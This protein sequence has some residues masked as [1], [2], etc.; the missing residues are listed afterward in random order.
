MHELGVVLEIFDLIEEIMQERNLKE[1]CSVTVEIGELSGV[2]PDYLKECWNA[3]RIGGTFDKT[4]LKLI[5]IPSVARC[6]CGEEYEMTKNSRICPSCRR[7]DYEI[8]KGREFN[9]LSIEAR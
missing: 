1:V 2:L 8:I 7:T 9:V 5:Y 3:A 4:E 6:A